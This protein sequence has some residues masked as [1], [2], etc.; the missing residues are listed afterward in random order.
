M[1]DRASSWGG[2]Y[3][4]WGET[5][6]MLRHLEGSNYLMVDGHVKW[7]KPEQLDLTFYS[8]TATTTLAAGK[9]IGFDAKFVN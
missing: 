9:Q 2:P 4:A 5:S 8:P 1:D 6:A 7:Y 3:A